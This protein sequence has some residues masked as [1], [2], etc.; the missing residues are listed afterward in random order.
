MYTSKVRQL[1]GRIGIALACLMA[2]VTTAWAQ[3]GTP[4]TPKPYTEFSLEVEGSNRLFFNEGLYAGQKRNYLSLAVKPEFTIDWNNGKQTLNFVGFA[5]LDQHD[6][7]RTH[8]DVRELYWQTV[9]KNTELSVG[10]KKVFWGKTEA[11]HLVDIIN[12]TDV[13][14]SF[15]G[16]QK[17]GEAMLHLSRVT[18]LG[19]VDLFVMP[20]FRKRVFPGREGRLRPGDPSGLVLDSRD[21]GFESSAEEFRPS[22]AARWS[23]YIGAFDLAVSHFYGTGREPIVTDLTT[24]NAIYGIINQTGLELQATTGPVLWKAEGI[25][26]QN[27]FQDVL[28]MTAGFEY[29]FGNVGNTGLDIGLLGEYMYD[30]RGTLTL[31]GLQNDVFAGIRLALNDTQDSQLLAGAIFDTQYSTSL[32]FIEAERRLGNNWSAVIEARLFSNVDPA[33]FTYLLR[34][35]G[36]VQLALS[37]FF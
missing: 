28:A 30:D 2:M 31:S 29:T 33:E 12:Q 22:F 17:L 8:A 11:V 3:Q 26:R 20:W 14:E 10:F 1:P 13:V 36:F 9:I 32:Y 21:F 6:G 19:T 4:N 15:D 27:D 16:E 34:N 35:D 24:F 18:R 7:R 25:Y 5:R 37:R 23:H